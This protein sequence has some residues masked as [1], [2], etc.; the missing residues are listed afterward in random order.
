MSKARFYR[1][2]LTLS[3][4]NPVHIVDLRVFVNKRLNI[5]QY[6]AQVAKK[7]K[8]NMAFIRSS[9]ACRTK[10]AISLHTLQW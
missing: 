5:N 3:I 7:A 1:R 6:C 8:S 2:W 4:K 9:V 10:E